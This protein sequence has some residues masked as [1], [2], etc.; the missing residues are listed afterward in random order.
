MMT[1]LSPKENSCS[2]YFRSAIELADI[3]WREGDDRQAEKLLLK[4][5]AMDYYNEEACLGLLQT[6]YHH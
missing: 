1:G 3:F 2:V 6:V 5:M 4:I